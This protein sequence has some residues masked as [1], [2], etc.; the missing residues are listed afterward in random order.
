MGPLPTVAA[1]SQ[2][3]YALAFC[4]WLATAYKLRHLRD[5]PTSPTLRGTC[6][7]LGLLGMSFFLLANSSR[8][9]V[10]GLLGVEN[11][12]RWLGNSSALAACCSIQTVLTYFTRMDNSPPLGLRRRLALLLAAVLAMGVLL[13]SARLPGDDDFVNVHADKGPV[14]AYLL[15]Y[16]TYLGLVMLDMLRMSWRYAPQARATALQLA[17]RLISAGSGTTLLYCL[18]KA[19]FA[20]CR[21]WELPVL[22]SERIIGPLLAAAGGLLIITGL[23]VGA[24]GANL[25]DRLYQHRSHQRLQP[26]WNTLVQTLPHIALT[27][28]DHRVTNKLYRRVIEIRDAQLSLAPYRDTRIAHQ[29]RQAAEATGLAGQD[30]H[31]AIEG[32]LLAAALHAHRTDQLPLHPFHDQ[33]TEQP[34][35]D[36]PSEVA[37][38]L[39]VSAAFTSPLLPLPLPADRLPPDQPE[40]SP[41]PT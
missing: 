16:L 13:L 22:G 20:L 8:P 39:K 37:W 26:L 23:T 29:A 10:D 7:T 21:F 33:E 11:A 27:S 40:S 4:C 19:S 12:A 5:D 30:L 3:F 9:L 38:L 15:I 24:W 36:L 17:L 34:S 35:P 18:Y 25:A 41:C 32:T 1:V 14:L 6:S 28:Y 2:L 31:A